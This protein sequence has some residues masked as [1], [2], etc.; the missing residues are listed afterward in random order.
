M[1]YLSHYSLQKFMGFCPEEKLLA[2]DKLISALEMSLSS[3]TERIRIINH[4]LE[5]QPLLPDDIPE[6]LRVFL[7]ELNPRLSPHQL[8]NKLYYYSDG[9]LRKDS[10]LPLKNTQARGEISL[11]TRT[12]A[13]QI[14]LIADNLRSV[15]NVGSLFR[16]AECL[17]I[18][19]IM[20]CGISPTPDH[21]H[22]SKTAMS[23]EQLVAW[24]S[25]G[26]TQEAINNCRNNGYYIYALETTAN[27]ETVFHSKFHFPLALVIGNEALGIDS[28]VLETCDAAI[29]LPQLGWKSSLNV[30]VASSI[31]LYQIIFGVSNG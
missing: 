28:E 22:I 2:L 14:T 16:I 5:L 10:Q 30:G 13:S 11:E 7:K 9:A 27:A 21:P 26:T 23:T 17:G 31:A 18:G 12:K 8:L 4:I 15:F 1:I 6:K 3:E 20:L 19:Q 24:Q 25:F 29:Y